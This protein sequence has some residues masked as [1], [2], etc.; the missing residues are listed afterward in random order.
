MSTVIDSL[1]L[2]LGLDSSKFK[3][4]ESEISREL[5]K[6]REEGRRT[7]D[8][9]ESRGKRTADVFLDM[10]RQAL[11]ALGLFLGGRGAKEFFD[12]VVNLDASTSRLAKTM[13]MTT[14]ETSAWQGAIKQAGGS[15]EGANA[16]LQGLS[17]EMTRFQMT[18]QSGM[19]PVLTRLGVGLY[20]QNKNLKTS[21]DLWLDLA[22]AVKGMDPRQ[23]SQF[24][25]MIPGANQDMINFALLGRK[26]MEEYLQSSREAGT[27]TEQSATAAREYQR[28][29]ARLDASATSFGRTLTTLV[30]PALSS[31][32]EGLS[33]L[34]QK[35]SHP[36]GSPEGEAIAASSRN[37]S[38]QKFGSPR[39]LIEWMR[40]HLSFNDDD[41][42]NWD[43]IATNLYGPAGGDE[44]DAAKQAMAAQLKARV[45]SSL[46]G[47]RSTNEIESYIR[48]AAAARGIDP[49]VAVQVARNEG[50]Y[51]YVGDRGS[52]FGPY[53]LHY[54]G[55]AGGGMAV[56]GL[57][58]E[59]TQK[60]GLDARDSSTWKQQIDFALD[61]A[62]KSGWG[63][64]H[65]WHGTPFAGIGSVAAAAV[66]GGIP[67]GGSGGGDKSV[68]V[69][70]GDVHIN[71][72]SAKN[73]DEIGSS[74][75]PSIKRGVTAGNALMGP[76]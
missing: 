61:K 57:G 55:V 35:S 10:K 20:D 56:S 33:K 32:M 5:S 28:E 37:L 50:L 36:T 75:I 18:G 26:A 25:S 68:E 44:M 34:L 2:E 11:T 64:W 70:F 65:G 29:M 13:N 63:A 49:N 24:L 39:R 40:D 23:A 21:G 72:P 45:T 58:D 54:G 22:D 3:S 17:G 76:N 73:G 1:V 8:E 67:G 19:L 27:T 47:A 6:L 59:F 62:R 14:A 15:A 51:N 66:A 12:Y 4:G 71:A 41:W 16:A 46:T 7:G 53:Q 38:I 48:S 42:A 52:S 43:D 69:N 30:A 60:T 74:V 31:V 9:V